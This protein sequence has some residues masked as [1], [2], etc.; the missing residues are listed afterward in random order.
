MLAIR[1]C[2]GVVL[3]RRRGGGWGPPGVIGECWWGVIDQRDSNPCYRHPTRGV[4]FQTRRTSPCT[5]R[6]RRSSP[7]PSGP[8][9]TRLRRD[10]MEKGGDAT[11]PP[12]WQGSPLRRRLRELRDDAEPTSLYYPLTHRRLADSEA[13]THE[14]LEYRRRVRRERTGIEAGLYT[15][16]GRQRPGR[17]P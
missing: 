12:A 14:I 8:W 4:S 17:A 2:Q 6:A 7:Y 13:R 11:E 5:E 9:S 1:P 16:R 3:V 10:Y 15:G